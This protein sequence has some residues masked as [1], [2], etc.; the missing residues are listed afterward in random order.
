MKM[1]R[2]KSGGIDPDPENLNWKRILVPLDFTGSSLEALNYA[3][4]VARRTGGKLVLLHVIQFPVMPTPAVAM[5]AIGEVKAAHKALMKHAKTE[6]ESLA[7]RTDL[8]GLIAHTAV[9][10]G[11]AWNEIVKAAKRLDCDLIVLRASNHTGIRRMLSTHTADH[12]VR[13]AA[14]AVLCVR[15]KP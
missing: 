10:V 12:V 4:P 15:G 6:L 2:K 3:V 1:K 8:S 11:H 13:M 5:G 9:S 7:N 14:C